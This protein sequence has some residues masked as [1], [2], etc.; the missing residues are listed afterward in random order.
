MKFGGG[1]V[2]DVCESVIVIDKDA[3]T[4]DPV[5]CVHPAAPTPP[6][7]GR[8]P[9]AD[10]GTAPMTTFPT[11]ACSP[12][13]LTP[14]GERTV[15]VRYA[16]LDRCRRVRVGPVVTV[17]FEDRQTLWFRMQ[18]LARV[19]RATA[20]RAGVQRALDWY[21]G[22]LP[23]AGRLTAAV[24]VGR[25]GSRPGRRLAGVRLAAAGGALVL[26]ADDGTTVV[27][28]SLPG[29][30]ADPLIGLA[31]WVELRFDPAAVAAFADPDRAWRL[32][33]T[34]DG[35]AEA[36]DPLPNWV[37]ESLGADLA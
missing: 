7:P 5:G 15:G 12:D 19:A 29:R 18:E 9:A 10:P 34:A 26:R 3:V 31:R 17:T 2:P 37:R 11:P 1:A 13:D 30:V 33:L 32:V 35:F 23:G 25:D 6:V 36:S 20:G 24:W 28:S 21:T 16:H 27:A 4:L 8:R 14:L 22:L